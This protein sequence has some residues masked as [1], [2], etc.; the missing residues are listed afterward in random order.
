VV[1]AAT[2]YALAQR[3]EMMPRKGDRPVSN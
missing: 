3:E 1:V 2:V